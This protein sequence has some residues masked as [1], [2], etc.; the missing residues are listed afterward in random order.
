MRVVLLPT[1][2][3]E[4]HGL[5][6]AFER[7]FP[8]H[9]FDVVPDRA[10]EQVGEL[11]DQLLRSFT[12]SRLTLESAP[13]N[14]TQLVRHASAEALGERRRE[15]AGL[16]VVL[17]DLELVNADQ[18]E[19]VLEVVRRAVERHLADLPQNARSR[20]RTREALRNR[21]SF[22]LAVPMVEAWLFADP[23]G[24]ANAGKPAEAV[25]QLAPGCDPERF[26]TRDFRYDAA[27]PEGC[28][29]WEALTDRQKRKHPLPWMRTDRARHPKAYLSW[30]C[31]SPFERNCS[32]YRETSGGAKALR[33][34]DW[35]SVLANPQQMSWLRSLVADMADVLGIPATGQW[36]GEQRSD[37]LDDRRVLRN[38]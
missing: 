30:L 34:L 22:H 6:A 33:Q 19:V 24:P 37:H 4:W 38:L 36:V 3:A 5:P 7:L 2:R 12:S 21:V 15:A 13:G 29:C 31:R 10:V 17:D 25:L 32:S 26:E 11:D 35:S 27:G 1:G 18:P 16:V 8:D 28:V 14:L 9:D 20:K 23:C